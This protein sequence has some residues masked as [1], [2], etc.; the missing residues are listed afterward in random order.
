MPSIGRVCF[1]RHGQTDTELTAEGY[2]QAQKLA[3]F[4][5]NYLIPDVIYTSPL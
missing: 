4:F 3:A 1:I 5:A 2:L